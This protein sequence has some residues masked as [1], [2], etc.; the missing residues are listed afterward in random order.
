MAKLL[1]IR[2]YVLLSAALAG[3]VFETSS[4]G[5]G[6]VPASL[7]NVYGLI[8][9]RWKYTSF[10]SVASKLLATGDIKRAVDSVGRVYLEL[11]SVG[12]GNFKRRFPLFMQNRKWDGYFMIVVFDIE[13]KNRSVRQRL[14][15]KLEELG[16]GML[17]KSVWI[18]PYHFEEDMKKFLDSNGLGDSALILTARKLLMKDLRDFARRVWNVDEVNKGYLNV[19]NF[20][21]KVREG[22]GLS[23]IEVKKR[24]LTQYLDNLVIDPMLPKEF[25]PP[26][27][28]RERAL[29]AINVL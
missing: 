16:F 28:A 21:R 13:E 20:I 19:L 11:T 29:K 12:R 26:N 15:H 8:P 14:R 10:L 22:E 7:K 25:L 23:R 5:L 1:R 6:A 9:S 4:S 3:E 27:W 18:S 24:A 17:Q 2:D